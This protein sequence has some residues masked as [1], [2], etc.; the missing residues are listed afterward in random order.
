VNT[1]FFET[2]REVL[3]RAIRA[4]R[5]RDF[6]T[7]YSEIPS[8]KIYGASASADGKAAFESRLG[9]RFKL[10][11][12][13]SI[14]EVGE[15]VSPY[16]MRLA[17]RYPKV[18]LDMLLAG[19]QEALSA[20]QSASPD[21]RAGVC[22]EILHRLNRRSFE[23]GY[24][25]MHTTGQ[26]F[27]M[28]FQAGGP[29]AQDRGLEA[30]ACAYDE[31]KRI[32]ERIRWT[33]P[34]GKAEPIAL[35]KTYRT[36]GRGI[37]LVI[38]CATMPNWNAYPAIF[39]NLITGN[40]VVVKPHPGA[41]LPLAI[42]VEVGR[43]V[44]K[45]AGFDPNLIT[46]VA[47]EAASPMAKA[48]AARKEITL[49]DYTGGSE[50]GGWL[51]EN[52]RHAAVFTAK[53]GANSIILDETDDLEGLL[54]NLTFSLCLYSGQ[55]C[56]TPQNI[57]IPQAGIRVGGKRME[58]QAVVQALVDSVARFVAETERS[59]DA[60]GAIQSAATLQRIE[61][62]RNL[63]RTLL[64]S[65]RLSHPE[66]PDS[67]VRTPLL[68]ELDAAEESKYMREVLGPIF[69]VVRTRDTAHSIELAARAARKGGGI[70]CGLYSLDPAVLD[71]AERAMA[72]AGVVLSCNLTGGIFVNQAAAFSDF[73]LTSGNPA[74]NATLVDSA[75]VTR[76][77]RVCERRTSVRG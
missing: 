55:M 3:E 1:N 44:L 76:R 61:E 32:P 31:M 51:E 13:G 17:V 8:G 67:R 50:F 63:G 57:F 22:L 60:L 54:R 26:A 69:I 49:I 35:E 11:Q 70:T 24:A 34:Q 19:V 21:I 28:A 42:T 39:A 33:K 40:A 74:G 25:Q 16:G 36:L 48:L 12:P 38:A 71:S 59:L 4:L 52:A 14:G 68:L 5:E 27:V 47:D 73:H 72:E 77:F 62:Y 23:L 41:V 75:F 46:L 64:D 29:H 45:E 18:D 58:C 66:F 53:S 37:G 9:Q 2:H 65:R 20:W 7:P 43:E 15:E 10:D 56:T 6:W 30:V